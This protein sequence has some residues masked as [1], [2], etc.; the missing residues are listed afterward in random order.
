[1]VADAFAW[2]KTSESTVNMGHRRHFFFW[3]PGGDVVKG[4]RFEGIGIA[5]KMTYTPYTRAVRAR[6]PLPHT[7]TQSL[8]WIQKL[9]YFCRDRKSRFLRLSSLFLLPPFWN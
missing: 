5:G 9:V 7:T 1:M 3:C 8:R 2:K 6:L 4:R